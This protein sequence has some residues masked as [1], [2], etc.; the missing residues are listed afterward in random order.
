MVVHTSAQF[1]FVLEKIVIAMRIA[2]SLSSGMG[3][4][5]DVCVCVCVL[6]GGGVAKHYQPLL[7]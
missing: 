1:G 5:M 2:E 4:G 6:G 3:W 7:T